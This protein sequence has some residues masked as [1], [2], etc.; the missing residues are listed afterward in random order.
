MSTHI[1]AGHLAI[2]NNNLQ[3][4][5]ESE[6]LHSLLNDIKELAI[7]D[8]NE[9]IKNEI[10]LNQVNR[11]GIMVYSLSILSEPSQVHKHV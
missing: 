10:L 11:V 2:H 1:K 7:D 9:S 4:L 6:F 3:L 8:N 5:F